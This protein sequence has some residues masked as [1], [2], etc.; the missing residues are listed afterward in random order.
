MVS[1]NS[2]IL[3][4]DDDI[5]NASYVYAKVCRMRQ[6]RVSHWY[7]HVHDTLKLL[8]SPLVE[9]RSGE[10]PQLIFYVPLISHWCEDS[11]GTEDADTTTSCH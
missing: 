11:R 2:I 3:R 9:C 6:Q 8:I 1:L 10:R 4:V 7:Q 5:F